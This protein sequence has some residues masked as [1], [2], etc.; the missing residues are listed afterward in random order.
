[1]KTTFKT[2]QKK[3][4]LKKTIALRKTFFK[5]KMKKTPLKIIS[6]SETSSINGSMEMLLT[7]RTKKNFSDTLPTKSTYPT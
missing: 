1:M 4:I 3:T 7:K 2:K 5:T 6:T